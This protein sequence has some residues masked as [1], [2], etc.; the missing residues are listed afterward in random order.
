MSPPANIKLPAELRAW[1]DDFLAEFA[2]SLDELCNADYEPIEQSCA[3]AAYKA[4]ERIPSHYQRSLATDPGIRAWMADLLRQAIKDR[5]VVA[6]LTTGPSL[7]LLGPTGTGKTYQGYGAVFGIT[8]CGIRGKWQA[9]SAADLYARLRPRHGVDSEA[10][11]EKYAT[12]GLLM[13]DDLGVAKTSEWVEEVNYRLINH[14]YERDLPTLITSN[15]PPRD[16]AAVLGERVASRLAEM[17]ERV[18]LKG[19]DRRRA[20]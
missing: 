14:R 16:L 2:L 4:A 6:A 13:L 9:I 1:R 11:F 15:V 19:S 12:T 8:S 17:T 7:L 3:Q 10:E 5:R 20:A 18:T